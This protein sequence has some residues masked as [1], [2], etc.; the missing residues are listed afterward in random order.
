MKKNILMNSGLLSLVIF[1]FLSCTDAFAQQNTG[2]GT[3]TPDNSAILDLTATT[4]G[5]L[6][7][8]MTTVQRLAIAAPATGLLVYDTNFN[9]FWYFNGTV[10][11]QA[12]GPQGPTGPQGAQGPTGLQGIQGPTG[13]NGPTGSQGILGPTGPQGFQGTT[14]LQGI[15]GPTGANG[16]NGV[17]GPTGLQGPTGPSGSLSCG[18]SNYVIKSNGL[19]AICTVGPIYE[20][21]SGNVGI[22]NTTPA[23]KLHVYQTGVMG[24]VRIMSDQHDNANA[25]GRVSFWS[26]GMAGYEAGSY[27]CINTGFGEFTTTIGEDYFSPAITI[28]GLGPF[29]S[30]NSNMTFG[31]GTMYINDISNG[32]TMHQVGIAT[33]A[34]TSNLSVNGTADKTGGGAWGV[35][36]DIRLKKDVS[37]FNDGLSVIKNINPVWFNYNGKAGISPVERYVGVVAQDIQKVAPY[38]VRTVKMKLNETDKE[39]TDILS[40]DAS[41]LFFIL[42]NAVKEQQHTIETLK[43]ENSGLNA[44]SAK[45]ESKLKA[46]EEELAKLKIAIEQITLKQAGSANK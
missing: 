28:Y 14:G 7:P 10:W 32:T 16:S 25:G 43:A 27:Q 22:G 34:P 40:F 37:P 35:F 1:L 6:I 13:A 26:T 5:L 45:A 12:I 30:R 17:T 19:S 46:T 33:N 11:V 21:G 3:T 8:R 36:S 2:I 44:F 15:Q 42:V 23:T 31:S 18:N 39:K 41:A 4:K 9:Q 24:D 29:A 38:M 20:D